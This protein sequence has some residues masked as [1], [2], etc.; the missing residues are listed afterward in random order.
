MMTRGANVFSMAAVHFHPV[1][2][3]AGA[4]RIRGHDDSGFLRRGRLPTADVRQNL[5]EDVSSRGYNEQRP[6]QK[7]TTLRRHWSR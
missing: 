2:E 5:S 4:L 1:R 7:K 3:F 6:G